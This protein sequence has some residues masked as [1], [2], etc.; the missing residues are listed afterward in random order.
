[1][2]QKDAT[3]LLKKFSEPYLLPYRSELPEMD[4]MRWI[5]LFVGLSIR[6][7]PAG[8]ILTEYLSNNPPRYR[9]DGTALGVMP[10]IDQV[11]SFLLGKTMP[12]RDYC[13]CCAGTGWIFFKSL[14]GVVRCD[15]SSPEIDMG[16]YTQKVKTLDQIFPNYP[17]AKCDSFQCSPKKDSPCP[18]GSQF[19]NAK[20]IEFM[21]REKQKPGW[22]LGLTFH[23]KGGFVEGILSTM[24]DIE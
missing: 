14:N 7:K 23:K 6:Y 22:K 1:M 8:V 13:P 17:E 12:E 15:C 9:E 2:T 21:D 16:R 5:K 3:T 11:K 10:D 4:A 19:Y 24:E 20:K 18:M